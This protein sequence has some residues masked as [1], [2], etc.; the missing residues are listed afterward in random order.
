MAGPPSSNA[1][2]TAPSSS[3]VPE[4][5]TMSANNK[6]E[7]L[8]HL[9]A[10]IQVIMKDMDLAS[11]P[12][13]KAQLKVKCKSML[14]QA[15]ELKKIPSGS[16]SG[17]ADGDADQK[18]QAKK[19]K[20]LV[21]PVSTRERSKAEQMLV[22]KA[23]ALNGV[24][25][26][27][28]MKPP[29][30]S[31]FVLEGGKTQ[32]T[33]V[34]D[35]KL[36]PHQTE[37]F[38]GFRRAN[39]ALPP[40]YMFKDRLHLGPTM[41]NARPIDLVQD[42]A[43][44][45]SVV[46]SLCALTSRAERGH[47]KIL[48]NFFYPWDEKNDRPALSGSGKYVIRLNFN[49]GYR[50]C[51]VDDRLPVSDSSRTLHVIDRKNPS[52]LWP[53]IME[54]A[55][56]KLRGGYNFPG[57]NSGTDLWIMTGWIPEQ[58]WLQD[59]DTIPA[60]LW[61]RMFNAFQYGDILVT[62]GTG[63]MD[64][65]VERELG[66]AG[67]HDYAV[68]DMKE[69]DSEKFILL[70]NPWVDG[71]AWKGSRIKQP[72]A[73]ASSSGDASPMAGSSTLASYKDTPGLFWMTL[74]EVIQH[75]ES[76]YLNWNPGLFQHRQDIH[77]SWNLDNRPCR[78]SVSFIENPQFSL[79]C[80][81][82][83]VWL[84][85]CRYFQNLLTSSDDDLLLDESTTEHELSGHINIYVYDKD[86]TPVYISGEPSPFARGKYV[87]SPQCLLKLDLPASHSKSA[88]T[89]VVSE[90]N[91]A[92]R[93]H[94]F[95]MSA[96]SH[97]PLTLRHAVSKY[98]HTSN[99]S[100]E[101]SKP[102]AGGN[103]N[104]QSFTT[105]PQYR[106]S[107]PENPSPASASLV[108]YLET[109]PANA[110]I[111]VKLLHS[112][113]KRLTS[114]SRRDIVADSGEYA[115]GCCVAEFQ[116]LE[117]KD[118][119]IIVS[120]FDQGVL[121]PFTLRVD[122]THKTSLQLLPQE[123]AGRLPIRL[124]PASFNNVGAS[125]T[126]NKVACPI[127]PRRYMRLSIGAKFLRLSGS[128]GPSTPPLSQRPGSLSEADPFD[129]IASESIDGPPSPMKSI[130]ALEPTRLYELRPTPSP[131]IRL[132]ITL[133]REPDSRVLACTNNGEF[134]DSERGVRSE[135]FDLWPDLYRQGVV[136]M[137]VERL[138]GDGERETRGGP[139]ERVGITMFVEGITD[140]GDVQVGKWRPWNH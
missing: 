81:G 77:F 25:F 70:K 34:P 85:L 83:T 128:S 36:S 132:S 116:D 67:Q 104:L 110:H 102:C 87:D 121:A 48:K 53:A 6:D 62:M 115:K 18:A 9:I 95:S 88:Y 7:A 111:N 99:V 109:P 29:S 78:F 16:V 124:Y 56:L 37:F 107:F 94:S 73:E 66:L 38:V 93:Q 47:A 138:G 100:S 136:W 140:R 54:K 122:S 134:G 129:S 27:L 21:E 33:D 120:T 130:P 119:T 49:G 42:A 65:R 12:G 96:F 50:R 51:E 17:V 112:A 69:K 118:Y 14:R 123:N 58:V 23:G 114:V 8:K 106:L 86:G 97:S 80:E 92:A 26:H 101:W 19:P 76:I 24:K 133:G 82:G 35:L 79:T 32:F 117:C 2:V 31:E 75:F 90:Q 1:P 15:E 60:T 41:Q 13:D 22:L 98:A 10:A 44:D 127:L 74:N 108:L 55:Y 71:V 28:W 113:G 68:L 103:A 64:H 11:D 84:L 63:K 4:Q 91:L 40:P 39:D 89:V 72:S 59:D 45:C 30:A 126:V 3:K 46:A 5:H 20:K 57:S 135:D 43:S 137:V 131:L 139:E 61:K 105:N 52:L 125:R